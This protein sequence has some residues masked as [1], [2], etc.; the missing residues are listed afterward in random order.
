[1]N[2]NITIK[3]LKSGFKAKLRDG[4]IVTILRNCNTV[5]YGEQDFVLVAKDFFE[6]GTHYLENLKCKN[7]ASLDIMEIRTCDISREYENEKYEGL[8]IFWTRSESFDHIYQFDF[9]MMDVPEKYLNRQVVIVANNESEAWDKFNHYI[10]FYLE[11]GK[12]FYD[13]NIKEIILQSNDIVF[14]NI[15]EVIKN[16]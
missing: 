9:E 13:I 4:Q 7:E 11:N 10:N 14:S 5:L 3:D 1:M 6:V 15:E 12:K 8:P 16:G 2:G